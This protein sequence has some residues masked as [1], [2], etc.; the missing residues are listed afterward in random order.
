LSDARLAF[1]EHDVARAQAPGDETSV[2]FEATELP[3]LPEGWVRSFF[4]HVTGWA[5]D[6]DPNTL[7]SK[8]VAPLHP[9]S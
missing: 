1:D 2:S 5:K 6:Q 7:F 4:L 3:P 9:L 8:T